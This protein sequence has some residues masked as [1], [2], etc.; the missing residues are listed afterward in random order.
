MWQEKR[1]GSGI[2]GLLSVYFL[3][4]SWEPLRKEVPDWIQG[5]GNLQLG[6]LVPR[7]SQL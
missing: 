7:E 3:R 4:S 2:G 6:L 5:L 1:L